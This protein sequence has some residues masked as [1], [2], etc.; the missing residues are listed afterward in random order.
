MGRIIHFEIHASDMK[1]A[2][3][4]YG[5]LFD[6]K[7]ESWGDG[8]YSLI[9]TGPD[10]PN[11]INGGMMKRMGPPPTEGQAVSSFVSVI[12][13]PSVDEWTK[14]IQAAGGKLALPKQS[15]PEMGYS[16]YFKDPDGNLFGIFQ[17]DPGAK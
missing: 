15:I 4:F 10:G 13:V 1:K 5:K 8:S 3:E 14:K 2:S 11:G 17:V 9:T 6:W 12:E 7:F 16:A